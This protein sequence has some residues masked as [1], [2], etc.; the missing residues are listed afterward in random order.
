MPKSRD[1][2]LRN[3]RIGQKIIY[4]GCQGTSCRGRVV[5]GRVVSGRFDIVSFSTT[6]MYSQAREVK[7]LS[8]A[9]ELPR[10][11]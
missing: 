4:Q 11:Y 3:T 9:L 6:D 7:A 1:Q 8:T 5:R 10:I 2:F